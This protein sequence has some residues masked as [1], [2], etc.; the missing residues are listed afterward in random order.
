M[1][2]DG[3]PITVIILPTEI[4]DGNGE[5]RGDKN[6]SNYETKVRH[7]SNMAV[8][9]ERWLR[10]GASPIWLKRSMPR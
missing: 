10:L 9:W 7:L 3:I 8:F 2:I 5:L 6:I 4:R 1:Q